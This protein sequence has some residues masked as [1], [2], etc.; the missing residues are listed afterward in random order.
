MDLLVSKSRTQVIKIQLVSSLPKP[1]TI[2]VIQRSV[3]G[4]L[5]FAAFAHAIFGNVLHDQPAMYADNRKIEFHFQK[6]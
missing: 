5:L 3:L 1:I 2:G 4:S 6:F